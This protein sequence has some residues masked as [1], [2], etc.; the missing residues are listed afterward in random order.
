M[1]SPRGS[2]E[3]IADLTPGIDPRVVQVASHWP[4]KSNVNLIMDNEKCA[5]VVGSAPAALPALPHPE[6]GMK[7]DQEVLVVDLD[8]CVRC[9]SCEIACR[10]ENSF[11]FETKS[12]WCR[13]QTIPPR[14]M[15]GELHLDFV[16][17]MCLHCEEPM[18][19][20]FCPVEAI[21]KEEDG[22]VMIDGETCIGLPTVHRRLPLWSHAFQRGDPKGGKVRSLPFPDGGRDRTQLRPALHRRRSPVCGR[23]PNGRIDPGAAFRPIGK[24]DL[25]FQ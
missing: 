14:E 15:G 1:E 24:N 22:R 19:A 23:P 6:E 13:V 8:A 21:H 20:N 10:Q 4:G 25:S 17:V 9:Y 18:C 3:G 16:P 12:R 5:P 2:V 7:M 11:G